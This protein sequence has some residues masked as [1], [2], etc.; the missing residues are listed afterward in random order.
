VNPSVWDW[1]VGSGTG[2]AARFNLPIDVK[3]GPSGDLY[4]AD[5]FNHTIRRL[6]PAG[7]VTK[8]AGVAG[9][10]GNADGDAATA[11][12]YYPS[13]IAID[14]SNNLSLATAASWCPGSTESGA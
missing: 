7:V 11:R 5:T 14:A 13:G 6:T 2:T 1:R 10:I 4:V 8:V 3:I 9:S 12:F